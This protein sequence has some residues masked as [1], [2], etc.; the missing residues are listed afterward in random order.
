MFGRIRELSYLIDLAERN[1]IDMVH[2][3]ARLDESSLGLLYSDKIMGYGPGNVYKVQQHSASSSPCIPYY[4]NR[5]VPLIFG[6]RVLCSPQGICSISD[7]IAGM[8]FKENPKFTEIDAHLK[9]LSERIKSA[10][11]VRNIFMNKDNYVGRPYI[12]DGLVNP[13]IRSVDGGKEVAE[14]IFDFCAQ[15]NRV[16]EQGNTQRIKLDDGTKIIYSPSNAEGDAVI[17][18]SV[19]SWICSD[20]VE[21]RFHTD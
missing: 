1:K 4:T 14:R 9:N 10:Q 13:L 5:C 7:A 11:D 6:T 20:S 12:G 16:G 18:I 17:V 15:G 3:T 2:L 21:F 19:P 8:L